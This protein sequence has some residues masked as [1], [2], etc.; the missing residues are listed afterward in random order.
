MHATYPTL[1]LTTRVVQG[2]IQGL[3]QQIGRGYWMLCVMCWRWGIAALD[4]LQ[5]RW[6]SSLRMNVCRATRTDWLKWAW[7]ST[8]TWCEKAILRNR[9]AFGKHS[10]CL[11]CQTH[12]RR[13][14]HPTI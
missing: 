14:L 12:L 3:P 2:I 6:I 11:R 4:L 9:L 7:N 10:A 13:S 1:S 8:P 5:A